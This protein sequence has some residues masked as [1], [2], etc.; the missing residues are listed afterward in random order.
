VE[1]LKSEINEKVE[2]ILQKKPRKLGNTWNS[3][4][5]KSMRKLR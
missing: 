1:F 4:S 3:S 5:P 2:V